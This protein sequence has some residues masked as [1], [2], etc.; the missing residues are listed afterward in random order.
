MVHSEPTQSESAVGPTSSAFDVRGTLP[1]ATAEY[2]EAGSGGN[3][4]AGAVADGPGRNYSN[5]P[6]I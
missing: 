3:E 1:S 2:V 6:T 4:T 5:D